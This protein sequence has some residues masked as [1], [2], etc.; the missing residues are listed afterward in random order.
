[1]TDSAI[2]YIAH[3]GNISG[4]QPTFENKD[5]YLKHAYYECGHDIELDICMHRGILYYG[6]DDCQEPADTNFIQSPGVFCHAKDFDALTELL[7]MRTNCFWHQQDS[8]TLTSQ[9]YI[10]CFPGNYIMNKKAIWIDLEGM[11]IP[12][13]DQ[14][15]NSIYGYC[16]DKLNENINIRTTR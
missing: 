9:N 7:N 13:P 16:G 3:R 6:H 1:M 8:V 12:L 15:P 4:K 14:V 11:N 10:W 2:K 5:E